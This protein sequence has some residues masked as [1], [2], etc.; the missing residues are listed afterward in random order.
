MGQVES[1]EDFANAGRIKV[2]IVEDGNK[3][4][5][6][7]DFAFPLL[8]KMLQ[9]VPKVGEC[10][11]VITAVL[12]N[13]TSNRYYIGPIVSQ[14]QDMQYA[15]YDY[16][17]GQAVAALK[18][19]N[20]KLRESI[21][22]FSETEGSFPEKDTVSVVGRHSEDIILKDNEIDIRCGIRSEAVGYDDLTGNV[23]FNK[24]NPSYIQLRNKY[25]RGHVNIVADEV[26]IIS[27]KKQFNDNII[28]TDQNEL[29]TK[30]SYDS[31]MKQLHQV[32]YGDVLVEYLKLIR[33]ALV[34]HVHPWAQ[35]PPCNALGITDVKYIDFNKILSD[36]LR[37]S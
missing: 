33:D 26:N 30:E 35:M 36:T 2:K 31:L 6:D 7:L 34:N 28:L 23:I 24:K 4:V 29:I 17:R 12:N 25:G 1:I 8:P 13:N 14:P 32:P 27:H 3:S 21:E 11:L 10:V 19:N 15:P 16:N 22:N 9:I 20:V 37:I 5:D 18:G